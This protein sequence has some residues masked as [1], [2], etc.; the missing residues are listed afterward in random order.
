MSEIIIKDITEENIIDWCSVCVPLEKR[1]DPDWKNG[2]EEKRIW[3]LEMLQK[4]GPI[5]KIG[6]IDNI[7]A[8]MIQYKPSPEEGVVGIDCIYVHEKKYWRKGIGKNLLFSLI[9]DM[10]KPQ[11]WFNDKPANALVVWTFA[12]HSEGQ[13]SA[14]EFFTEYGF[15]KVGEN[16]NFLYYPLQEGFVYQPV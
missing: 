7:P 10:K 8:G 11:K 5:A 12:G 9:E 14:R 3:A 1:E 6:Y 13:L 2:M 4:W 16:P 15:K